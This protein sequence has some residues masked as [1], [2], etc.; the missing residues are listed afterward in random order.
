M[1]GAVNTTCSKQNRGFGRYLSTT[2][3]H[4]IVVPAAPSDSF[5]RVSVSY[6]GLNC[7]GVVN[8]FSVAL[9]KGAGGGNSYYYYGYQPTTCTAPEN[10]TCHGHNFIACPTNG[11]SFAKIA[12]GPIVAPVGN[13][14]LYTPTKNKVMFRNNVCRGHKQGG[15]VFFVKDPQN[16]TELFGPKM[17]YYNQRVVFVNNSAAVGKGITTQTTALRSTSNHT[18]IVV[19][20]YNSYL[21][22]SL[23]FNLVDEFSNINTTD[24]STTVCL[25]ISYY[26]LPYATYCPSLLL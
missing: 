25:R 20:D 23:S 13:T 1:I 9:E 11:L 12:D 26:I 14:S 16:T 2:P 17:T 7:T 18:T 8:Y 24:F 10:G 4:S 21:Q 5:Y 3:S 19:N 15:T 6:S 22:P